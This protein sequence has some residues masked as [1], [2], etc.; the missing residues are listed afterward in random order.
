MGKDHKGRDLGTGIDQLHGDGSYRLRVTLYG[1]RIAE[2]SDD[3]NYLFDLRTKVERL[4]Q[5]MATKGG[6]LTTIT[7]SLE[8]VTQVHVVIE[9]DGYDA[10]DVKAVYDNADAAAQHAEVLSEPKNMPDYGEVW[11]YDV[12]SRYRAD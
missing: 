12:Q 2:V 5:D 7:R 6:A 8:T 4:R 1:Q 3:L 11:I 9:T 10:W